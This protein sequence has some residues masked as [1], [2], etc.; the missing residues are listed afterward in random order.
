MQRGYVFWGGLLVILGVL[1]LLGTWFG[2]IPWWQLFWPG[3]LIALGVWILLGRTG[4]RRA[5]PVAESSVVTLE[6][7]R[8][9]RV[10][11]HHGAGRLTIGAGTAPD[12]LLSGTFGGGLYVRSSREGDLLDVDLRPREVGPW[13]WGPHGIDWAFNLNQEVPLSLG[14]ETGA[15]DMTLDLSGLRLSDLRLKTGA[16]TTYLTLPANAGLTRAVIE[17]GA[18]T[19]TVQVPDGVAAQVRIRGALTGISVD[20][21]RFPYTGQVYRSA[22]YDTA[23]NKVDID[24]QTG[25]GTI[26]VR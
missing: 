1:F 17:S 26:T 19:M 16:S 18:A 4:W 22:D 13:T 7:A 5:A 20:T 8:R 24:V 2:Q 21:G 10:H 3:V 25:V 12:Q 9:A 11:L 15:S 14:L 23:A 6:G